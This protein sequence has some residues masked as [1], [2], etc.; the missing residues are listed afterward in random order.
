MSDCDI[1]G[2]LKRKKGLI[3]ED[4][5]I[6]AMLAPK[7]AVLGHVIILP[8]EHAPI[9]EQVPDYVVAQMFVL[10]N[11]ISMASFEVLGAEGTNI[12]VQNGTGAGQTHPHAMIHVLPRKQNDNLNMLWQP[13]EMSEEEMSTVELKLKDEAKSIGAFE[14]EKPKPVE[15]EKPETI[16]VTEGENY[17]IK[18]LERL[19]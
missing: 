15:I 19:P 11:K 5:K 16:E 17:L 9:I 13:K 6:V 14:T 18:Q 7:P 2:L 10:A 8:K 4:D 3:Y 12:L 1:C